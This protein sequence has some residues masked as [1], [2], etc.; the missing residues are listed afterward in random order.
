MAY[1]DDTGL[2]YFWGKIKAWANSVFA[3][4]GHT[5]PASDVTLMTGYSKP[6]SGSAIAASDTLNQAVGKLEAKVDV[7]LD[8]S[9]YVHTTGDESI[10][11]DK[12]F[13]DA[14]TM[15]VGAYIKKEDD[16]GYLRLCGG[17]G[18][19]AEKGAKLALCGSAFPGSSQL[20]PNSFRLF[21]GAPSGGSYISIYGRPDGTL[22]WNAKDITGDVHTTGDETIGGVKTFTDNIVLSG[23]V[24]IC[25][26]DK[27]SLIRICG[28]TGAA[29]T[30][31]AK[32]YAY[33]ASSSTSAGCF[34]AATGGTSGKQ[35]CG[36]PDGTFTWNGNAIQVSSDAR[37]K[38]ELSAV[39]EAVLDVWERVD[40]GEFKFLDAVREKGENARFHV[41]LIAQDVRKAFADQNLDICRYGILCHEDYSGED[42]EFEL[43]DLWMVRYTEALCMEAAYQRRENA[44]LKKRVAD[45]EERLAALELRLG[46]E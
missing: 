46:S 24:N 17:S 7:A 35:F 5:H 45:L 27:T 3:L 4:L 14:A 28:G 13:I 29:Y 41:G 42:S 36:K 6:A 25:K 22:T 1:L 32:F 12:K 39:S 44:R 20:V 23:D 2:A 19:E 21:T 10:A 43:E 31:G 40:W 26:P 33:G 34:Y 16:T 37:L 38:T 30:S 8:D 15:A 11:G 9:G 18:A